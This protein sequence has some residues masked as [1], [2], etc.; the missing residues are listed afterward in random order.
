MLVSRLLNRLIRAGS[1]SVI[2]AYGHTHLVKGSEGLAVAVRLYDR[3]LHHQLF[4]NP[5]LALG[6]A[7]TNGTLTV[8]DAELYDFLDLIGRNN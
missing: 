4:T 7:Y 5:S 6:E 8:K 2:D 3:A 1:L